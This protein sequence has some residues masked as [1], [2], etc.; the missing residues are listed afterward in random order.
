VDDTQKDLHEELRHSIRGRQ[1][2][3]DFEAQLKEI[4]TWGRPRLGEAFTCSS[5]IIDTGAQI[6]RIDG[7][8]NPWRITAIGQD[9]I[10]VSLLEKT[11]RVPYYSDVSGGYSCVG[12]FTT[13]KKRQPRR[14]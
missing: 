2:E 8:S 6:L 9:R 7:S 11:A 5:S 4:E 14:K 3:I 12:K 13:W 1:I 10:S